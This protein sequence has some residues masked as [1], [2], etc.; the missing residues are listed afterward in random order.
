MLTAQVYVAS[1]SNEITVA[2]ME[3]FAGLSTNLRPKT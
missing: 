2:K 3:K 1:I